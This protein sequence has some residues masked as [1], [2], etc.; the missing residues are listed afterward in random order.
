MINSL[1]EVVERIRYFC[2]VNYNINEFVDGALD[3][4][5][6]KDHL[7][8]CVYAVPTNLKISNGVAKF[9]I[10]ITLMD[11]CYDNEDEIK[12]L[13]DLSITLSELNTY[14]DDDSD[15]FNYFVS[16]I[17]ET[18]FEAF[19]GNQDNCLGW[20]GDVEFTLNYNMNKNRINSK[21]SL[22]PGS[23]E[24]IYWGT[25]SL[26]GLTEGDITG[27]TYQ[28]DYTSRE[29]EI[30]LNGGGK[31]IYYCYPTSFGEGIFMV[32]GFYTAFIMDIVNLN[33]MNYYTYRSQYI[34]YGLNIHISIT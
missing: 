27:L 22:L 28:Y 25:S 7:Y 9:I 6:P 21:I 14:F 5:K 19:N 1:K 15:E 4:F 2:N 10:N 24:T 33:G 30:I 31:Y 8:P 16:L 11:L 32:N 18:T 20:Q 26:T 13:S 12:K 34:Q 17:N 29:R 3:E 23:G